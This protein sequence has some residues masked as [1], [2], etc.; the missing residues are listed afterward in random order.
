MVKAI[1]ISIITPVFSVTWSFR[2]CSNMLVCCS[3]NIF[4]SILK[5]V[6][7]LNI[8]VKPWY[9]CSCFVDKKNN[10]IY[11]KNNINV[12]TVT[13]HFLFTYFCPILYT[14]HGK[15]Q[16]LKWKELKK[17]RGTEWSQVKSSLVKERE[18]KRGECRCTLERRKSKWTEALWEIKFIIRSIMMLHL[19]IFSLQPSV[20]FGAFSRSKRHQL[21]YHLNS[22]WNGCLT[23]TQLR[24]H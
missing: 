23:H 10:S 6:V 16:L 12:F 17:I 11:L 24:I 19:L 2:N 13:E 20:I 9:I 22:L 15:W 8:F 1:F 3:R 14:I 18:V 5:T 21:S 7:L 4:E